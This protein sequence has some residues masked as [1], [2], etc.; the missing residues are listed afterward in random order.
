MAPEPGLQA[1]IDAMCSND[2]IFAYVFLAAAWIAV[3]FVVM[4]IAHLAPAGAFTTLVYL[5][6]L[7]ICVFNTASIFAMVRHYQEDK[8]HI[9]GQ[10]IAHL[11]ANARHGGS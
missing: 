9:Y 1:R 2:R 4:Q 10:D 7:A 8:N 5:S 3:W 11:D 6:G